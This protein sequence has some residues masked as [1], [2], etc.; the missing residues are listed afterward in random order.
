MSVLVSS[1]PKHAHAWQPCLRCDCR[2]PLYAPVRLEEG[3]EG[4]E[5]GSP[6]AR[7]LARK[8][9]ANSYDSLPSSAAL[10]DGL[11]PAAQLPLDR[12]AAAAA[13]ALTCFVS[14]F[15]AA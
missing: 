3:G 7:G 8:A 12:R 4:G 6:A 9:W 11:D 10:D 5:G 15:Q 13:A 1:D 2:G 14:P